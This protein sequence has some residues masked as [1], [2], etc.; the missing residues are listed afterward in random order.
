MY[1][2]YPEYA[3]NPIDMIL[4]LY[5]YAQFLENQAIAQKTAMETENAYKMK[6][7]TGA[8]PLKGKK[9]GRDSEDEEEED[10]SYGYKGIKK[11]KP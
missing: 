7:K 4:W 5:N 2:R 9:K 1:T 10:V 8:R 3:T 11:P 6:P